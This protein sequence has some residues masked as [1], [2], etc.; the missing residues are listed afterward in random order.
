M[1]FGWPPVLC[2]E[3]QHFDTAPGLWVV[4]T[5]TAVSHSVWEWDMEHSVVSSGRRWERRLGEKAE[6]EGWERR[7]G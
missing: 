2:S 3:L 4:V 6:R 7:L 1:S 5:D